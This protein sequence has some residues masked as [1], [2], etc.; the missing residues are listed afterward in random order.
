MDKQSLG[1]DDLPMDKD[2]DD[3]GVDQP[4]KNLIRK[5]TLTSASKRGT[6]IS[7]LAS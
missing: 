6:A 4:K 1:M 3:I 2:L 5:R 7:V